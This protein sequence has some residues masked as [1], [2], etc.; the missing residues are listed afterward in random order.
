MVEQLTIKPNMS[1]QEED[2]ITIA[3]TALLYRL[4]GVLITAYYTG[5][6]RL[7]TAALSSTEKTWIF[8]FT[9]PRLFGSK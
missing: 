7:T 4:F 5:Y 6:L 1:D 9:N 2:L 3:D 8:I